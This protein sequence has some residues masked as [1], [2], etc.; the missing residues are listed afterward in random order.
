MNKREYRKHLQKCSDAYYDRIS[1]INDEIDEKE[2]EIEELEEEQEDLEN[3]IEEINKL[4]DEL[5]ED[6][7][8]Y[9]YIPYDYTLLDKE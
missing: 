1:E 6:F 7:G 2:S 5:D 4:L 9:N 3:S 8:D